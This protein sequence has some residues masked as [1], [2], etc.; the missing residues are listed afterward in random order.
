[1]KKTTKYLYLFLAV[2]LLLPAC[3]PQE[4]NKYA[5]GDHTRITED[6]IRF[7]MTRGVDEWTFNYAITGVDPVKTP[8]SYEVRFGDG[9]VSKELAGRYEYISLAAS[10]H[11]ECLIS[12]TD[13]NMFIKTQQIVLENDNPKAL[14]DDPASLQFALT[15]G[16]DNPEGKEWKIGPWTAMR[17]PG[18]R[19]AV[20]WDGY[21]QSEAILD[22]IF[23]FIPN[24]V[25]PNGAFTHDNHGDSFMNQA[26]NGLFPEGTDPDNSFVTYSYTPPTDATWKITERNGTQYLTIYKGFLGYPTDPKELTEAEYEVYS[27]S[28]TSIKLVSTVWEGWCYELIN[29]APADPLTGEVSK[30][31]V[32]DGYNTVVAE[33]KAGIDAGPINGFMGLGPLNEYGQ[34]WWAAGSGDKSF[35]NVGWTLYDWTLTFTADRKLIIT[36]EGE[37]Y[38]RKAFDGGPSGFNST[39]ID[40]DDM[41][42]PYHGGEYTYTLNKS[43]TPY[44]V[45][46]LSGNAFMGY[47]CG[48][49]VYEIM[50]LSETAMA[51]VVHDTAEGQDWVFVYKPKGAE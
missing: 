15:G 50:Y 8:F 18:D 32:I 37:G 13:G 22:D 43:A 27:Y 11:V 10:F 24:G 25:F 16:K 3:A 33:A 47:Y 34:G 12:T 35:D 51:I 14:I 30:T 7:D 9:N 20:W 21:A 26:L 4:F 39:K 44:P 46:T 23:T 19:T 5:L 31:W 17:D 41:T 6:M 49:Q 42:F 40:G 38:G 48:T 36:T 1:M 2:A 45:L 28:L 29:D